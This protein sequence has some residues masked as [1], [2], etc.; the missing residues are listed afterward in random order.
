MTNDHGTAAD[1]GDDPAA[2]PLDTL[3]LRGGPMSDAEVREYEARPYARDG[4]AVRRWDE[5]AKVPDAR[6]PDFA[7]YRPLLEALRR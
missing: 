7:R 4:V 1:T 6:V 3:A 2:D 5:R